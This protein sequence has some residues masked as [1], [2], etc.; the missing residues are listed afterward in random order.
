[1]KSRIAWS[2]GIVVLFFSVTGVYAEQEKKKQPI[3]LDVVV[4]TAKK[5]DQPMRTG[6][7]DKEI[8]P[9]M[10]TTIERE[11][12]EG[13]TENIAEII[14][15]EVGVQVRQ[16]GGLGSFST[17]SLRGASSNQVLIFM[18]GI[19]LND[20]S[21]GG[22]DLS[23]ISL[24]DVA[25]ID[26]YRGA[27]PINFGYSGIGGA[28]NIRTLRVEKGL[29]ASASGG[30]GS[31]NSQKLNGF[32]N[33]KLNRFDYL[34]SADYLAS[35]NDFEILNDN[36]TQ[37]NPD[38]DRY[39]NRNNAQVEQINVLAK[40]G[41]DASDTLRLDLMNQ[42][43]IKDQG[44][45]SWNNSPLTKSTLDTIRNIA[46]AKATA[47]DLTSA[48]LNTSAQFAY[49][50]KEEE[51]DDRGGHIG[52][53]KQH[54]TYTTGRFNAD[55]FAEWMGDWQDLIGT[56]NYLHETYESDD[57]LGKSNPGD[58]R[59]DSISL[60]LQDSFFFFDE[61]LIVTP[62][63]RYTWL[64]DKLGADTSIWGTTLEEQSRSDNYL[65]P[66][67]GVVYG[68]LSWL[69]LKSNLAQY[70]RQPSFFELFGDRG[71][72]VGNPNLK[73]ETGVN[74][75]IG[76]Q[77]QWMLPV[78]WLQRLTLSAAYFRSDVE[79]LIT[80]VYD[81][82]GIGKSV[83]VPGALI[84]G[85]EASAVAEFFDYFRAVVNYTYQDPKNESDV[86][87]FKEKQLPGRLENSLLGRLE[88]RHSGFTLFGEYVLETGMYYD[89]A[90]LLPAADK[91]ELNVGIAWAQG[92]WMLK[93]EGKN[94]N[95]ALYEDF[96]GF[97]LPGRSFYASLKYTFSKK[98]NTKKE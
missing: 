13:K 69:K 2:I 47:D 60:G 32:I 3:L 38:D 11:D 53:A 94:L 44:I 97:P 42:F 77:G 59:R 52:L 28:V 84:Q 75:D 21:G 50:W 18:D 89:T 30:Y 55:L 48:H 34:L 57:H 25:A 74:F 27:T 66:Q 80:R 65:T 16:S 98:P 79:D 78:D 70:V 83:N 87:A 71:L 92:P 5:I 17:V 37:W 36:G 7:V 14:E 63:A 4:V 33:H 73:E 15:K 51:Y 90:N 26:I 86:K 96:N 91:K 72:F 35:D 29:N 54:S 31:F 93:L 64:E 10:T 62:A 85:I 88:A 41:Y 49:T 8:T 95:D 46:T 24:S 68:P 20:T 40:G 19:L 82:R 61:T 12:F 81:A 22:V 45:P 56:V 6:D 76:A 67:I 58:S 43:F 23:T 39:E 9:V 1:M